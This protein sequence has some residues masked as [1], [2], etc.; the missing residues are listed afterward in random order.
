VLNKAT[1]ILLAVVFVV[2]SSAVAG[3]FTQ[4]VVGQVSQVSYSHYLDNMLYTHAGDDRGF[5]PEHDLARSN[6]YSEF[7][8]FGLTAGLHSF[9]YSGDTYYNVIATHYGTVRP[10]DIYIVGAHY[11]SMNNPGADDNASGTAGVLEAA[12]VLSQ[13]DF[14]AT[15]VFA[16]FDRE[17]QGLVGSRAYADEHSSSNILGMISLDM[18]AYNGSGENKAKIYGRSSSDVLKQGLADAVS[19]YGDGLSADVLGTLNASDH[20]P[21]EDN[22]FQAA[23]LIEYDVWDNPYYHQSGDSVD[24]LGYIDYAFATNMVGSTVGFLA[25][26]AVL[27]PE[28]STLLLLSVG[29]AVL[30]RRKL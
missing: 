18:I 29:V 17:E 23:L 9:S 7:G 3:F 16:C 10:D 22:G 28:P 14:E 5:G 26:A 19:L 21:F 13:Y 1:V 4:D 25:D 11:D 30:R 24:T 2:S 6:I 15:L 12:R 27:V 8:T 20:A